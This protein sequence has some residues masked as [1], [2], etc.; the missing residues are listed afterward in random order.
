MTV[1]ITCFHRESTGPL[2]G[3]IA[4]Y[5]KR[6]HLTK[7]LA[8]PKYQMRAPEPLFFFFSFFFLL[9]LPLTHGPDPVS[10]PFGFFFFFDAVGGRVVRQQ[11]NAGYAALARRPVTKK[12]RMEESESQRPYVRTYV[13]TT[14][15]GARDRE[16]RRA[17][18]QDQYVHRVVAVFFLPPHFVYGGVRSEESVSKGG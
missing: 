2:D 11:P 12:K 8:R 15:T 16:S 17:R 13:R 3:Q 4:S 5:Y 18:G 6:A 7:Q 9:L 10:C 1:I 14:V